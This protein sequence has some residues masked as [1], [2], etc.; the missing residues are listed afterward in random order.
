MQLPFLIL[1]AIVGQD[2]PPMDAPAPGMAWSAVTVLPGEDLADIA[3]RFQ[4]PPDA[5]RSWNPGV[6]SVPSWG[7]RLRVHSLHREE[8][9]FRMAWRARQRVSVRWVSQRF[10]LPEHQLR[11]LNRWRKGKTIVAEGERVRVYVKRS[12]WP[13]GYLDGGVQLADGPGVK[14]K[15]PEWAWGRPAAVRTIEAVGAALAE[16]FPGSIL[17]VGDLSRKGGGAFPPHKSHRE[18][19]DAD[20]GLFRLGEPWKIRFTDVTPD[21]LDA[22][23]TWWL[24][25]RLIDTGRVERIL[26]DWSLQRLLFEEALRQGVPEELLGEWF[27]Y[28]RSRWTPEGLIRHY[29]GHRH[30]LH[31]RFVEPADAVIL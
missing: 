6:E 24:L 3:A 31:L 16:A 22:A 9:R 14:V 17:V 30:H 29:K 7:T 4:V 28:P 12:R 18:G 5:L 26:V 21:A 20:I 19:T 8:E 1:M 27:Q 23:R 13:G 10:E 25:R 2:L 15:H 11:M